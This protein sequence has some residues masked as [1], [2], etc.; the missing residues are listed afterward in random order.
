MGRTAIK[1]MVAVAVL[2]TAALVSGSNSA[3]AQKEYDIFLPAGTACSFA[4]GLDV[5]PGNQ[6][7][8]TLVDEDG[9]PVRT[10]TAGTGDAVTL[11]NAETGETLQ[12]RSNGAVTQT[13]Y[14][15]D[16]TQ[17]VTS[18]GHLILILFPGDEPAGPSTTLIAGRIV[19]DVVTA[20]QVFTVQS[21]SGS[22]TDLC[23][24]LAP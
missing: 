11:T 20:T 5:T 14:N 4:V 6:H 10:I 9:D 1:R 24:L 19:Y 16:G 23:A 2:T 3:V 7:T 8:K 22:T 13:V 18:T 17:T 12:F 15:D 21:I